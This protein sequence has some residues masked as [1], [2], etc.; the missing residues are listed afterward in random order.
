MNDELERLPPAVR[1]L[2]HS[3]GASASA[4]GNVRLSQTGRMRQDA[5]ANWM[6]FSARQTISTTSCAFEWRARTGPAGMV[7]VRD[8][9]IKNEGAL[10]VRALRII[11]I[12]HLAST[13]AI[14]RGELMRYLA[15]LALAPDSILC[16]PDIRWR[17]DG[18]GQLVISA[19]ATDIVAEVTLGLDGEGRIATVSAEDRPRAVKTSFVPTPWRGRFGDYRQHCGCWLPFVAEV[20][21]IIDGTPFVYWEGR[22]QTWEK[23]KTGPKD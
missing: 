22:M 8:A 14:T 1:D 17:S 6:K 12:A 3:L 9:L 23:Q 7:T 2:A 11:P 18:P 15:E 19:G 5:T 4:C 10:D 21:W 13:P 20:S 16:N